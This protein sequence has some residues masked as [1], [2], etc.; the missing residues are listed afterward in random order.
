MVM[1]WVRLELYY[2]VSILPIVEKVK[3]GGN[4]NLTQVI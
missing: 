2:D 4:K 3:K 1:R